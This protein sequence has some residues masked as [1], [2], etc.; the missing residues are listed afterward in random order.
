M[1]KSKIPS[2]TLSGM[3]DLFGISG[4]ISEI[5]EIPLE[6]CHN[7]KDHPFK[8]LDNEDM[9]NL[10]DSIK[11]NGR[12]LEPILVRSEGLE[13]Y[14]IISGHRRCAAARKC[15]FT[16]IPAIVRKYSDEEATVMMVDA[17]LRRENLTYSE[18]AWAYRMKYDALKHQG[19]AGNIS[20]IDSLAENGSESAKT[21]Q[22]LIRLT[23]LMPELL[24]LVDA[25][26]IPY[27]AG[28][29]LSYLSLEEQNMLYSEL[30]SLLDLGEAAKKI[31]IDGKKAAALKK[32]H[33]EGI[34]SRED[35]LEILYPAASPSTRSF[36]L[37][38][39]KIYTF[40]P[41]GTE[42]DEIE[43]L[44]FDLLEKWYSENGKG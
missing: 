37:K 38:S 20:S 17:N 1:S 22:R 41:K 30:S 10:V 11:L 42:D 39:D 24:E 14:E 36:K 7:F 26:R 2:V 23:Y 33:N 8:V 4:N 44:I 15:G 3:D 35:I 34:L 9:D 29:D 5:I 21:I 18:K 40:F 25:D 31:I 13:S 19:K 32:S 16:T 27:L 28:V 6:Q 12:V 43:Q